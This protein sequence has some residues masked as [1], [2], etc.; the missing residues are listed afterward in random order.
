M[1]NNKLTFLRSVVLIIG[2][3]IFKQ[4]KVH[5]VFYLYTRPDERLSESLPPRSREPQSEGLR[6]P[7]TQ[8]SRQQGSPQYPDLGVWLPRV[9]PD[10]IRATSAGVQGLHDSEASLKDHVPGVLMVHSARL[11]E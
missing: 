10:F 1:R 11:H 2:F 7:E 6:C 9:N 4:Y 3:Y 5:K 8:V